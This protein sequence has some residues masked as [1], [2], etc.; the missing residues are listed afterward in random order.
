MR[1]ERLGAILYEGQC[2]TATNQWG[3]AVQKKFGLT[4]VPGARDRA[5]AEYPDGTTVERL[6][7]LNPVQY[8]RQGPLSQA[9]RLSKPFYERTKWS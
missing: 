4:Y 6:W 1:P 8:R 2:C 3:M 9:D 7:D 5:W